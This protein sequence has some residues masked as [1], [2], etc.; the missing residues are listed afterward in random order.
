MMIKKILIFVGILLVII[1][2]RYN[3]SFQN[4]YVY[5]SAKFDLPPNFSHVFEN[6]YVCSNVDSGDPSISKGI[7]NSRI[8]IIIAVLKG[9]D[10]ADYDP[11]VRSVECYANHYGY[12]VELINMTADAK[13]VEKC[14]HEDVSLNLF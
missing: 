12:H 8:A 2:Y 11:A 10:Y 9:T 5:K 7:K 3:E 4:V 13:I 1:Y 6:N 14:P